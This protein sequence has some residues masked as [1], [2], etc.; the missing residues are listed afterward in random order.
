[1]EKSKVAIVKCD[2]YD[3]PLVEE[4]VRTGISLVGGIEKFVRAGEK[5]V[6]KPNVLWGSEPER[7]IVTHFTVFRA[8]AKILQE[9]NV[10]LRYGDS[11]GGPLA[12]STAMKKPGFQAVAEEFGI[13]FV[14]FDHGQ[15]VSFPD[16]VSAKVLTIANGILSSD[17]VISLPKLKAHGLTRI[18]GA[19]K[20]QFGC[21]PGMRKGEYHAQYPDVYDFSKLLVDITSFIRPRLYVMDA[22]IAMEGNGPQSGDPKKLGCILVSS[23]PVALDTVA[24]KIVD[25]D[26][27]FVPPLLFGNEF[28]LGVNNLDN[29][30]IVGEKIGSVQDKSFVVVRKPPAPLPKKR[31]LAELRRRLVPRPVIDIKKCIVCKRCIQ[32]CPVDPKAVFEKSGKK[33]P[34]YDYNQCIRCF[35]C[36]EMCPA[37]AIQIKEPFLRK[38]L[39]FASYL[40][41]FLSN[42]HSKKHARSKDNHITA[43]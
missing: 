13:E 41:L 33:T 5:I 18:T 8:V 43:K 12:A 37:K 22:I 11:P 28:G 2:S 16:G 7:C 35:C 25:L 31:F 21:V 34:Q 9:Q 39:P 29:I 10:K 17:G 19:V 15:N 23:D 42:R 38:L 14:D 32:V 27:D 40:A 30:E 36:H 4:A 1:M 26:P 24:C 3:Y 20:N 6:M